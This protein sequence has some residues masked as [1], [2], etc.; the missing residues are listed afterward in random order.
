MAT[1]AHDILAGQRKPVQL[2]CFGFLR[3]TGAKVSAIGQRLNR[4]KFIH[5]GAD[6]RPPER[7]I[8][9]VEGSVGFKWV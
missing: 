4:D 3:I 7:S 6:A 2:L 1:E 9:R 8:T 5:A